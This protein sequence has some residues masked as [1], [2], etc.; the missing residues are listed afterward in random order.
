MSTDTL[1]QAAAILRE[2]AK[3]A[4]IAPWEYEGGPD[5][6]GL[7]WANRLGDPVSGSTEPD[8][9]TYI[10]LMDPDVARMTAD[11]LDHEAKWDDMQGQTVGANHPSMILARKIIGGA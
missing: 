7:V 10:A 8:D 1:R 3:A 5:G 2:H 6:D 9:A 11:W 4:T